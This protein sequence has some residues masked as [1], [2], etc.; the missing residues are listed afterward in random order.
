MVTPVRPPRP[1]PV[2]VAKLHDQL[3][4]RAA[5]DAPPCVGH[6]D[7]TS[8]DPDVRERAARLCRDACRLIDA[9]RRYA[10]QA[11][12][13]WG[14]FGG[15]DRSPPSRTTRTSSTSTTTRTTTTEQRTH[16]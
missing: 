10:E 11:Q 3:M 8:D 7:H 16:A 2:D 14:V 12:E 6:D 9:C 5:A 15:V 1:H 13:P 4:L